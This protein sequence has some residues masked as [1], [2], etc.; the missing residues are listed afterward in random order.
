MAVNNV[1]YAFHYVN[2]NVITP[3]EYYELCRIAINIDKN[4][5]KYVV[6]DKLENNQYYELCLLLMSTNSVEISNILKYID[7][8]K[9]SIEQ[10]KKICQKAMKQNINDLKYCKIDIKYLFDKIVEK[11]IDDCVICKD[12]KEYYVSY[13]CNHLIC[14]DCLKNCDQ[15]YYRCNSNINYDVIYFSILKN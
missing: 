4:S 11:E 13:S 5:I 9:L 6:I 10:Y 15:C 12:K 2:T 1:V 8:N 14:L 3:E 7:N